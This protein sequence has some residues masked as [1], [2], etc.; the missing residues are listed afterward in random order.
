M[1]WLNDCKYLFYNKKMLKD[2][3]FTNPPKTWDELARAGKG[4]EETRES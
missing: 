3:G 2:A 4:H 1:P